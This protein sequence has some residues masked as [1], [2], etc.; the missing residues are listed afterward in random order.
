LN[1]KIGSQWM[2]RGLQAELAGNDDLVGLDLRR[3]CVDGAMTKAPLS[4]QKTGKNPTDGA[5]QGTKASG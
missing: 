3:Q 2:P 1:P 4:G 5:K